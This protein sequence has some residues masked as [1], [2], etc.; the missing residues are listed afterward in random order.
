MKL[1]ILFFKVAQLHN[2]FFGISFS[3][4]SK[5]SSPSLKYFLIFNLMIRISWNFMQLN[6]L[7]IYL[8][9]AIFMNWFIFSSFVIFKPVIWLFFLFWRVTT[10]LFMSW[11]QYMLILIWNFLWFHV[12][13]ANSCIFSYINFWEHGIS[14]VNWSPRID[15][16]NT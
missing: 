13:F 10:C 8:Q 5:S 4:I 3:S 16:T 7:A 6:G 1:F 14:L 9:A 15:Y 11:D 12:S 2:L